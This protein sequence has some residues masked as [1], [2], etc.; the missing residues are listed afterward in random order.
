[1]CSRF[2]DM[3]NATREFVYLHTPIYTWPHDYLHQ[4]ANPLRCFRP[5]LFNQILYLYYVCPLIGISKS[6]DLI[7]FVYRGNFV[8][9]EFND[10]GPL[11]KKTCTMYVP[12]HNMYIYNHV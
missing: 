1:M 8:S 11:S 4:L 3:F 9:R 5:S 7:V 2:F 12:V 10:S 6:T